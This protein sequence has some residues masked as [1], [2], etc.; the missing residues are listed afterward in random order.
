MLW[1]LLLFENLG[2]NALEYNCL[3]IHDFKVPTFRK[4]DANSAL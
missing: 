3:K 4:D 1:L 2:A